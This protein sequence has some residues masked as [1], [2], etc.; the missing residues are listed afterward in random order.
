[1]LCIGDTKISADIVT[2]CFSDTINAKNE[3]IMIVSDKEKYWDCEIKKLHR[4]TSCI[5]VPDFSDISFLNIQN[6]SQNKN[7]KILLITDKP[8]AELYSNPVAR[9]VMAN[10]KN[11]GITSIIMTDTISTLPMNMRNTIDYLLFVDYCKEYYDYFTPEFNKLLKRT[12]KINVQ[13]E[14]SALIVDTKE[15][16]KNNKIFLLSSL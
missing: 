4:S 1:M 11:Y 5:I 3:F 13:D 9:D 8:I 2:L 12:Y 7:I 16:E 15:S 10:N 6:V 14:F